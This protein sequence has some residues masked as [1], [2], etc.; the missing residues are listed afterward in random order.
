VLPWEGDQ[1]AFEDCASVLLERLPYTVSSALRARLL[2]SQQAAASELALQ[3]AHGRHRTT[4]SCREIPNQA[5]LVFAT[6]DLIHEGPEGAKNA[7][8]HTR[9]T[10]A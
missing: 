4:P 3:T 6:G 8:A 2:S 10:T 9:G 5:L 1:Q 7:V